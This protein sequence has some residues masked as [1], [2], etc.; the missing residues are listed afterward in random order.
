MCPWTVSAVGS[1]WAGLDLDWTGLGLLDGTGLDWA[2]MRVDWSK[3]VRAS[4]VPLPHVVGG[5]DRM[6]NGD[7][8]EMGIGNPL[9]LPGSRDGQAG[10]ADGPL[11]VYER[12]L[13]GW[14]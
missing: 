10:A 5:V 8:M 11:C 12:G 4:S 7:G 9:D 3:Q 1:D 14:S 2:R 6:R 13:A